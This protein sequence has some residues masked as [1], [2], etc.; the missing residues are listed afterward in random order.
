MD[1]ELLEK[2]LGRQEGQFLEFKSCYERPAGRGAKRRKA[3]EAAKDIAETLSAMAN[4]DGGTLL[5]GVEDDGTVSGVD[6]PSDKLNLLLEAPSALI[7]PALRPKIERPLHKG[8]LVLAF[9]IGYSLDTHQLTDGRYLLRVGDRNLPFPAEKIRA[10]KQAKTGTLYERLFIPHASLDDLNWQLLEELKERT[11]DPRPPQELLRDE[12]H[13]IDFRDAKPYLSMAALLL[14]AKDPLKWHPRCGV[15]FVKFEGT[16]RKYG[17]E[18]NIVKRVRIEEPLLKLIPKAYTTVKEHVKERVVLH[19]LFF[20]ERFE[21]PEFA[22]QEALVNAVAHRD[23]SLTGSS[24]ELWMFDDHMEV[25]SPGRLPDPITLDQ[26]VRRERVHFSR[27]PLLVRVLTDLG[28]MRELGEGIPRM[29]DEMEKNF[30]RPPEFKEEGFVFSV[31]LRNTPIFDVETQ[32]WLLRFS[33]YH[34]NSRQIRAL[35]YAKQF[36]GG[37]LTNRMYQKIGGV[38]RDTAYREIQEMVR[39]GIVMPTR[40]K[41]ARTYRLLE[42]IEHPVLT[43]YLKQIAEVL[44]EKGYLTNKDMRRITGYSRA[45]AWKR[46]KEL[47][48]AGLLESKGKGRAFKYLATPKFWQVLKKNFQK[49][50]T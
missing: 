23:Y 14:F 28:Y 46:M 20:R 9:E 29:F 3:K 49:R 8:K 50:L 41:Y 25:R 22:W 39:F 40:P 11:K 1:A 32:R 10:L 33:D 15:D 31:T 44:Q 5:V 13:L 34:L 37:R 21:Y 38:D 42:F 18:I 43:L 45:S 30:L 7:R 27:N 19:D 47:T 6:Y 26:L 2:L 4:A 36:S 48:K 12:Y 17:A 35:A 16:E 24:I